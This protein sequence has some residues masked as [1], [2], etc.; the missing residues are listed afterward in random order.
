VV[1]TGRLLDPWRIMAAGAVPYW[2]ESG[3]RQAAAAAE[4][5]LA[6]ST[7][8][9]AVTVLPQP[10]GTQCD[11]HADRAQW[12]AM[13]AFARRRSHVDS[14]A[15]ARYP[16]R[17][18]PTSRAAQVL[19]AQLPPLKPP[20]ATMTMDEAIRNLARNGLRFGMMVV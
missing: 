6:G 4:Q 18:L 14:Q 17:P 8:F 10:P 12:M 11:A 15:M 20:P 9:D 7:G 5:W 3:S 13:A 1:E 19:N 16:L 2:C